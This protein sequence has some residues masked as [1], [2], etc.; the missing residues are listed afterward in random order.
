MN[1]LM[2][3][4]TFTPHVGGVARSVSQFAEM[5]RERGHLVLV[6]APLFENCPPDETDVFRIP[7]IQRFNGTDFSVPMPVPGLLSEAIEQFVPHIVHSH[8]PFLLGD[9]AL[10]VS[11][12][13]DVPIVFTHHTQYEQY[14]HYVPGDSELMKRF[15]VDLAVG[16]CNLCDAVIA[17]SETI[18]R[19]L[20][21]QGVMSEVV[22]IPTGVDLRLFG[23]GDGIRWRRRHQIAS[24]AFVI[25]HVGRLAPEKG[26]AFLAAVVADFVATTDN[27]LFVVAGSGPSLE[28]IESCFDRRGI[29]DRL[30]H[31]GILDRPELAD[32]Y[33][34]LDLFAFASLSETQGMV[35]TE[36]M[37]GGTPV[38]AVDAPGVREVVLD[39]VNGR[40]LTKQDHDQ[41]LRALRW[42]RE[43]SNEEQQEF[44]VAARATADEFALP[45]TAERAL[46]LYA[47]LIHRGRIGL[48]GHDMWS[49]ARRRLE[50]EWR[51]WSNIASAA[52]TALLGETSDE[53]PDGAGKESP[54][55]E[56]ETASDRGRVSEQPGRREES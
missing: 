4:N 42:Y 41:F 15:V 44:R 50:N 32:L 33:T 21:E 36:A 19:R 13:Y 5:Y 35:L 52:A 26:L 28:T 45:R 12:Q 40:L 6:V 20:I 46:E 24:D 29:A 7:A 37:A 43:L 55:T 39:G 47:D 51:I 18:R 56:A 8:H 3:T 25:G 9:T 16:Y 53:D 34:A 30:L 23:T 17:P 48:H 22:E 27:C 38:V 10:R 49:N 11:A 1:I 31:L 54:D 2:F 14:T